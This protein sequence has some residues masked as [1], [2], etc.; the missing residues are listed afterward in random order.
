MGPGASAM[1]RACSANST[2]SQCPIAQPITSREYRSVS[3]RDK[4]RPRGLHLVGIATVNWRLGVFSATDN[5]LFP[6]GQSSPCDR[7]GSSDIRV[8]CPGSYSSCRLLRSSSIDSYIL[9]AF[10]PPVGPFLL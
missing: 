9:L 8:F 10:D 1:V 6:V 4:A 3:R 5:R 2:V 7:S